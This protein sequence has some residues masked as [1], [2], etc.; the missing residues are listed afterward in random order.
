[1]K[2]L[3]DLKRKVE[4]N[5]A[6]VN[7]VF[8]HSR[9]PLKNFTTMPPTQ[10]GLRNITDYRIGSKAR[11]N[12]VK[13]LVGIKQKTGHRLAELLDVQNATEIENIMDKYAQPKS[14][15]PKLP[16]NIK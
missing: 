4:Q 10:Y 13:Y 3:V 9:S 8:A 12:H 7:E 15:L 11:E 14:L 1:M 16:Y 6:G 2:D 5:Y